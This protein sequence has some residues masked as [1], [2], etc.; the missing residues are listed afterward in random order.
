MDTPPELEQD[1]SRRRNRARRRPRRR[2]RPSQNSFPVRSSESVSNSN[3]T[4]S[5][6]WWE[7][8][9]Y[10]YSIGYE[11]LAPGS[12]S[13]LGSQA[14]TF[15]TWFSEGLGAEFFLGY[16]K[17]VGNALSNSVQVDDP[18]ANTR[19]TTTIESGQNAPGN[20]FVG[21]N[22]KWTLFRNEWA[23]V[24]AGAVVGFSPTATA[25]TPTGTTVTTINDIEDPDDFSVQET[26]KGTITESRGTLISFGP[27]FGGEFYPKWIPHLA[28]GIGV[29]IV[30]VTGGETVTTTTATT[31]SFQ[32]VD[33]EAQDPVGETTTTTTD[34]AARSLE[35]ST[36]AIANTGFNLFSVFTIRFVW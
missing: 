32:V 11:S 25:E 29:G 10:K 22:L 7:P 26:A 33:G 20:I 2:P 5:R 19:I 6:P 35:S 28:I 34:T 15:G 3:N 8:E 14:V 13:I 12:S 24:H 31:K 9:T 18:N 30:A 21:A 17:G 4:D 36:F 23:L 1:Q 27:K 16:A